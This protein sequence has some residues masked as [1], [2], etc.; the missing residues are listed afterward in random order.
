ML[1][2]IHDCL[3]CH[4]ATT[5]M[6]PLLCGQLEKLGCDILLE[7]MWFGRG[8]GIAHMF[9]SRLLIMLVG[10][11]VGTDPPSSPQNQFYRYV[12]DVISSWF[13]LYDDRK[14]KLHFDFKEVYESSTCENI[15]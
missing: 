1:I 4:F 2:D 8:M 10:V 7:T 15:L 6:D 5:R 11:L 14:R 13:V 12:Q 9:I 3:S